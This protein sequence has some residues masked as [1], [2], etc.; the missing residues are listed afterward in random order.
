MGVWGSWTR[1]AGPHPVR[2]ALG[3]GKRPP[4]GRSSGVVR[5]RALDRVAVLPS[6]K[7]AASLALGT[8]LSSSSHHVF[9]DQTRT[10]ASH[11]HQSVAGGSEAI[12]IARFPR[13]AGRWLAGSQTAWINGGSVESPLW[14]SLRRRSPV[15]KRTFR[16]GDHQAR[17]RTLG[18]A[19]MSHERPPPAHRSREKPAQVLACFAQVLTCHHKAVATPEGLQPPTSALG[20]PCSMQLSYGAVA[21]VPS[22]SRRS[23]KDAAPDLSTR[24]ESPSD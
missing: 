15:P 19:E 8:S 12:G 14:V 18:L 24:Q 5:H 4:A 22:G 2:R 6:R 1:P 13:P 3:L 23:G 7:C 20:K 16:W 10:L 21:V 17:K 9:D 11:A